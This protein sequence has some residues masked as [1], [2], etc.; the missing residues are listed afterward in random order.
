MKLID[1]LINLGRIGGKI[2]DHIS[3]H[4]INLVDKGPICDIREQYAPR[5]LVEKEV[6]K[7]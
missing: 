6:M 7:I 1:E 5:A 4:V 3:N 2:M